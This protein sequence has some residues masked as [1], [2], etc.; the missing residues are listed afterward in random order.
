MRRMRWSAMLAALRANR[1]A[2]AGKLAAKG[3]RR[4]RG[5]DVDVDEPDRLLR[6]SPVPAR[7]LR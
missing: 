7:R 1:L 6:S 5:L 4:L 2:V 3:L